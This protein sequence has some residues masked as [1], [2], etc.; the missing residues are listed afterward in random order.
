MKKFT[1]ISLFEAST[2]FFKLLGITGNYWELLGITRA[3][4]EFILNHE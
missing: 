4:V 3:F 2:V 1:C